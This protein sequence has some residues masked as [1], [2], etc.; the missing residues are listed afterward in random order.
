MSKRIWNSRQYV[1]YVSVGMAGKVMPNDQIEDWESPKF[2]R[3]WW[4]WTPSFRS[5]KG[6]FKLSQNVDYN[7]HFLCFWL[8]FTFYYQGNKV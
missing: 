8:S 5:N 2:G 3:Y 7:F 6:K 1:G 4:F